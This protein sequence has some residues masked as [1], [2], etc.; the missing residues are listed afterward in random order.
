LE[1]H[2]PEK[3]LIKQDEVGGDWFLISRGDVDVFVKDHSL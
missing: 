2:E 3:S 1:V